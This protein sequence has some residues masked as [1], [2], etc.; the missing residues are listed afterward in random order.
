VA[1][2]VVVKDSLPTGLQYLSGAES[3]RNGQYFW[4]ISSLLPGE[5]KT[6]T[7]NARV[8]MP[9]I[10]TNT[11]IIETLDQIDTDPTNDVAVVCVSV[12]IVLCQG[13]SVELSVP[14]SSTNVQWYKDDVLFASGNTVL[15]TESGSYTNKSAE[16]TCPTNNCC[17]IVVVTQLCCPAEICIPITIKKIR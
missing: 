4:A 11:A 15:V 17:P 3:V 12:P 7:I 14:S 16:N 13:E 1:T 9:G 5:S 10:S 2:N 8:I 6:L